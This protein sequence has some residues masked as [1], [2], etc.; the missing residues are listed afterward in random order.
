MR[1]SPHPDCV[2]VDPG[3]SR[4]DLAPGSS[5]VLAAISTSHVVNDMMQSL[6]LAIYPVIRAASTSAS[7]RSA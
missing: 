7:P 1:G 6:I 4:N 2:H 3:F 5:G